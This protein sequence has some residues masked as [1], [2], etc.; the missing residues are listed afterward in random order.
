MTLHLPKV[1]LVLA[2]FS[3]CRAFQSI[4][5][6]R[7]TN[8]VPLSAVKV[9]KSDE[10]WK[11]ILRPDRYNVLRREGT[12]PPWTSPFNDLKEA[13]TFK[14]G[15]CDSPLFTTSTK[16]EVSMRYMQ[17]GRSNLPYCTK[18]AGNS[19][20]ILG[21]TSCIMINIGRSNLNL[22]NGYQKYSRVQDGHP[23]I[24]PSTKMLLIS[25]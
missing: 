24:R 4:S 7:I 8:S 23:F 1:V 13:G 16:Y 2:T 20:I 10:E 12:E 17:R 18:Y 5:I 15:G 6:R 3:S 21:Y 25:L 11:E 9:E 22:L 19:N 14:C